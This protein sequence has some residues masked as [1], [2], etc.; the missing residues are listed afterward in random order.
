MY[1]PRSPLGKALA[2]VAL[3]AVAMLVGALLGKY[4][5]SEDELQWGGLI[6]FALYLGIQ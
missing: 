2:F 6:P 1:F 5:V 4:R 3:L